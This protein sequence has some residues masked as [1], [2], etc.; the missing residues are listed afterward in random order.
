MRTWERQLTNTIKAWLNR[1]RTNKGPTNEKPATFRH[2]P[3]V[4]N[5]RTLVPESESGRAQTIQSHREERA[6]DSARAHRSRPPGPL[7]RTAP[8]EGAR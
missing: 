8:R 6:G 2:L 5:A 7:P 1:K 3:K 4:E